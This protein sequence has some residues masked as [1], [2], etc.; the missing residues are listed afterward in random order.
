VNLRPETIF[1]KGAFPRSTFRL[2]FLIL[3]TP[4]RITPSFFCVGSALAHCF[5]LQQPSQDMGFMDE[6][7]TINVPKM[8]KNLE[9]YFT[10]RTDLDTRTTV[11]KFRIYPRFP[12][13][14][15]PGVTTREETDIV[16]LN[17]EIYSEF[18]F[19]KKYSMN[20]RPL[21]KFNRSVLIKTLDPSTIMATKIRAI[22]F[23]K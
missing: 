16:F 10:K 12:I 20:I 3:F 22:L 5:D 2:W 14:H 23:H 19:C 17:V 18:G 6:M 7:K 8:A 11:E 9:D 15:D 21:F 4:N 13:L 1:L